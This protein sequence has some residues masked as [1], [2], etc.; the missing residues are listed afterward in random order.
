M[1]KL[2]DSLIGQDQGMMN[3]QPSLIG[4]VNL[5]PGQYMMTNVQTGHAFYVQVQN[6]QMF[7]SAQPAQ[8]Q[9]QYS[10]G[11]NMQQSGKGLIKNLIRNQLA[12][13]PQQQQ[14]PYQQY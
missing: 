11:Q 1:K 12:P 3:G 2:T 6:G 4:N 5:P 8:T 7:L 13:Q 14:V 9:Q 10:Q